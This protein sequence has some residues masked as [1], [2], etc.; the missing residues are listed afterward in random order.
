MRPCPWTR[1]CTTRHAPFAGTDITSFGLSIYNLGREVAST[2]TEID[3]LVHHGATDAPAVDVYE[4]SIPAGNIVTNASYADFTSYIN[5][6]TTDYRLEVRPTGSTTAVASY[7][8]PLAT[9]GL[10]DSA[11]VVVASGYSR[12]IFS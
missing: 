11:I 5:L 9:L 2:S 10:Q 1:S 8:A 4:S 7:E 12:C 6:A 3:V